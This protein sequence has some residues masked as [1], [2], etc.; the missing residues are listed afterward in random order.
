[1]FTDMYIHTHFQLE[2]GLEVIIRKYMDMDGGSSQKSCRLDH[3]QRLLQS[4]A[5]GHDRK[6]DRRP[7]DTKVLS[8]TWQDRLRLQIRGHPFM[9]SARR[10]SE[11]Q[12]DAFR[13]GGV[14]SMWTSTQKIRP[15]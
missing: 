11:V 1:M 14:S 7:T 12:V 6:M 9:M 4:I 10:G 5:T 3:D 13:W 15:H 2:L 8:E